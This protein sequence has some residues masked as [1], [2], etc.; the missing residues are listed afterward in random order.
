MKTVEVA[1]TEAVSMVRT[2]ALEAALAPRQALRA[3]RPLPGLCT[4]HCDR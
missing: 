4:L 1:R 2:S 3:S